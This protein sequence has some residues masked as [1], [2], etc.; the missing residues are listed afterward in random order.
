M[1]YRGE[2]ARWLESY[3]GP[4]FAS[5]DPSDLLGSLGYEGDDADELL[6]AFAERFEVDLT[7]LNPWYHYDADEPP[8]FRRYR[9]VSL[10]GQKLDD[11]PIALDD[12][13]RSAELRTWSMVYADRTLVYR[14]PVIFVVGAIVFAILIAA[15][16]ATFAF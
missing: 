10:D 6:S 16:L 14:R 12:L 1:D 4:D 13:A 8:Y 2:V 11:L 5:V 15:W 7:T 3:L 9:P